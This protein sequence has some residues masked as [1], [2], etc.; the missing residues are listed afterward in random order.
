MKI[1]LALL[2]QGAW[3]HVEVHNKDELTKILN[4]GKYQGTEVFQ[5]MFEVRNTQLIYDFITKEWK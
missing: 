2:D 5:V 3:W 1:F 4:T